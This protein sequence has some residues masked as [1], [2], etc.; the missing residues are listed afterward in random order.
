M[1]FFADACVPVDVARLLNAYTH[2]TV[3]A[4]LTES[5]SHDAPDVEWI[6]DVGKWDPR[7]IVLSGDQRILRNPDELKCLTESGLTW[8][9][10]K[11]GW[12]N[13][14]IAEV[15]WRAVRAFGSILKAVTDLGDPT[16]FEVSVKTMRPQ[17]VCQTRTAKHQARGRRRRQ[18][19]IGRARHPLRHAIEVQDRRSRASWTATAELRAR[20]ARRP[21]LPRP[22]PPGSPPRWACSCRRTHGARESHRGG[23]LA[24]RAA[25]RG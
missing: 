13:L 23:G 18:P 10:L 20:S 15:K 16:V 11:K 12:M 1:K 24:A 6:R 2:E 19:E 9:F 3:V 5:F 17:V 21:P 8:F 22:S 7:P 25:G 14:P 4:H